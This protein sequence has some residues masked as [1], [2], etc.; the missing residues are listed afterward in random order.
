MSRTQAVVSLVR[1][2]ADLAAA[3]D[4]RHEVFVIGQGVPLDL[5]QDGRD[6]AAEHVLGRVDGRPVAAARLLVDDGVA[7]VQRVAVRADLRGAGIGAAV[8][9]ALEDR[10]RERGAGVAELHAQV[11][12]RGF[13][14]RLGYQAFGPEYDEAG[15]RHVSM[16]KQL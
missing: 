4:V 10:A 5:E 12:V 16:R 14:E 7:L 6:G 11:A 15:I 2:P 3:L 1:T 13:Y 9:A 8:M